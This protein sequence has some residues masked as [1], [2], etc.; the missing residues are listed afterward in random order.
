MSQRLIIPSPLRN[1]HLSL[2]H[3][4]HQGINS[5][6]RLARESM[7]WPT[8]NSDIENLIGNCEIC[9]TYRNNNS[10]E[11]LIPHEFKFLPWNKVAIDFFHF[12]GRTY[13]IVVD[14]FSKYPEVV[15]CNNT[16]AASVIMNLKSIFARH[17]IPNVLVSDNGPPMNSHEFKRFMKDWQIEHVTS[18]PYLS[19]SNGL[20]ERSIATIK[21]IFKKCKVDNTDPYIAL[22]QYRNTPKENANISLSPAQ[23]LMSRSLR[24][25][26]PVLESSLKPKVCNSETYKKFN[27]ARL[28]KMRYYY[29]R[30]VK[31][32]PPLNVNDKVMFKKSP[33]SC[34]IP[35]RVKEVCP[36]PRSY[37]VDNNSGA[38]RRNRQHIVKFKDYQHP[39]P[40]NFTDSCANQASTSAGSSVGPTFTRYG[41]QIV[42]PKRYPN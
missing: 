8:I 30:N 21:N 18:S 42:P 41:R 22:L 17:G 26:L 2:L 15:Q 24:T 25:K 37:V 9:L 33:D 14:Y 1:K 6:K 5:C 27:D 29:N 19:R 31:D 3:E 7:Y 38:Y 12:D 32:L 35:G 40:S 39:L 23:L 20:V 36:E 28:S 13:L 11:S 10:K 34:W 16:A 4:G